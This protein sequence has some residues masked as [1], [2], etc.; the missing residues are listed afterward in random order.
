V[1]VLIVDDHPIARR[2]MATVVREAFRVEQIIEVETARDAL[3]AA[4]RDDPALILLDLRIPGVEQTSVLCSQ[5]RIA[6]PRARVAIVTAYEDPEAIKRCFAAGADGCLLKDSS[7]INLRTA[8]QQ[9]VA[10]QRVIDPRIAQALA[11]EHVRV[12]RGEP[13]N[14][15]L[16]QRERE[17][18]GLLAQGC[19][20]RLIAERLF[21]AETTVKG[22]V[23]NLLEKL[24]AR[25]RLQAVIRASEL[26]LL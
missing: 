11:T 18:L 24:N 20:N 13:A 3:V 22:Y 15:R 12:L 10:G 19:S 2:G 16:T 7:M 1:R 5:L 26:G 23:S 8:L 4:K 6:A 9:V 17:V 14:V 21:I 25:S